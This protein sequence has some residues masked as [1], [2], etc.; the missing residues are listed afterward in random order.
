MHAESCPRRGPASSPV[1]TTAN[2]WFSVLS[3]AILS[4]TGHRLAAQNPAD[5]GAVGAR[6]RAAQEP[7]TRAESYPDDWQPVG[8]QFPW[9]WT[10]ERNVITGEEKESIVWPFYIREGLRAADEASGLDPSTDPGRLRPNEWA[11]YINPFYLAKRRGAAWSGWGIPFLVPY[12][13]KGDARGY[14]TVALPFY[15]AAHENVP[16]SETGAGYRILFP[17][18]WDSY[19]VSGRE[20]WIPPF[21]A[22]RTLPG[23]RQ[24]WV[25]PPLYA[26]SEYRNLEGEAD[27]SSHDVLWPLIKIDRRS[28]SY[29]YRFLPFGW[30]TED[31]NGHSLL[32]TPFYYEGSRPGETFYYLFPFHARS[33]KADSADDYWALGLYHQG[34]DFDAEGETLRWRYDL[35]W[36]LISWQKNETSGAEHEHVLPLGYWHTSTADDVMTVG[37]PFYFTRRWLDDDQNRHE[38]DFVLGNLWV[39]SEVH[40]PPTQAPTEAGRASEAAREASLRE[41]ASDAA[42]ARAVLSQEEG[43]LY[44]LSRWY[45]DEKGNQGQWVA[46]FYFETRT[47]SSEKLAIW[48]LS[49]QQEDVSNYEVNYWRYFFLYNDESWN[50]GSRSTIGQVLFDWKREAA[51][52]RNHVSLLYPLLEVET[53]KNSTEF[54]V[55]HIVAG[56]SSEESGE[57]VDDYRFFP[58]FWMGGRDRLN[59]TGEWVPLEKHFYL[60]PFYGYEARTTKV[61]HHFLYPL[62]HLQWATESFSME[63][64]PIAFY[65]DNPTLHNWSVWPL[66]SNEAGE[67]AESN[68]LRDLMF[69]SK[70]SDSPSE[71]TY[72]LDPF[73]WSWNADHREGVTEWSILFSI[74]SQR[75]VGQETTRTLFWFLEF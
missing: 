14:G 31:P 24:R 47:E 75:T 72:R 11:L 34:T 15:Y 12:F 9:I 25:L 63:V 56:A 23:A 6:P 46:P 13:T 4:L 73:L 20:M 43:I 38:L 5:R 61:D 49:Y 32:L 57:R 62:I 27:G 41:D 36:N 8:G 70:Y 22:D 53:S 64:W 59:A 33:R 30:S 39:S 17:F 58:F 65:S 54:H 48:P 26:Y 40:G 60:L 3:L 44:P 74:Y 52:D 51:D 29:D 2:R 55:N 10:H 16:G 71:T 37:G 1:G 42:P 67:A 7:L 45:S 28:D 50:G 18:Y 19:S 21:W 69:L 68:W 66:H 35:L